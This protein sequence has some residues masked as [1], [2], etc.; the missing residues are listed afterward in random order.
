MTDMIP[1]SG[2]SP[3][4]GCTPMLIILFLVVILVGIGLILV[5]KSA[6]S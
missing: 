2:E 5:M 1:T 4:L 3:K 6:L